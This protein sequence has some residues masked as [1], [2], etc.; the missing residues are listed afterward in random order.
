MFTPLRGARYDPIRPN[1]RLELPP[2]GALAACARVPREGSRPEPILQR[3]RPWVG[4]PV[5]LDQRGRW[6][7]G[8]Q[9]F[10]IARALRTPPNAHHR[11]VGVRL[12]RATEVLQVL[13]DARER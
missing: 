13:G 5:C 2:H 11:V 4:I 7:E 6:R 3:V 12:A 1:D 8:R 9:A 10:R